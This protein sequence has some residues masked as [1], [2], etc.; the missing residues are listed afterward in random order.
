MHPKAYGHTGASSVPSVVPVKVKVGK[1]E[2]VITVYAFMD[3]GS[4]DSF[5][6]EHLVTQLNIKGGRTNIL[7]QTMSHEK[8]VPT[9]VV[10]GL[11]VSGLNGNNIIQLPDVFKQKETPVTVD[12]IPTKQ[13]LDRWPYL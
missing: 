2:N 4:R 10:S 13:D 5:F 9:Y 6:T 11:E 3:P 12:N 8:L 1:G 7:L